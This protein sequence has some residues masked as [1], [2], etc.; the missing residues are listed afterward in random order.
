VRA[1][2]SRATPAHVAARPARRAH[3]VD[4][5]L[6]EHVQKAIAADASLSPEAKSVTVS[7][8]DG[9]VTLRGTVADEIEKSNLNA[10]AANIP[11]VR[12]VD[13]Q[14]EVKSG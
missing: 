5:T 7:V 13:N 11:G 8:Q 1:L 2:S 14:L 9:T 6:E 4:R 3:A 12:R 10:I